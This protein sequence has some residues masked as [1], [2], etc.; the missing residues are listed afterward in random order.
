VSFGSEAGIVPHLP[1]APVP[2]EPAA[3]ELAVL[4]EPGAA[5]LDDWPGPGPVLEGLGEPDEQ[6]ARPRPAARARAAM[7]PV[8]I[9][10][11]DVSFDAVAG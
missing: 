4:A 5:A 7:P 10:L 6:A 8:R 3:G 1:A 11:I 2:G 9:A